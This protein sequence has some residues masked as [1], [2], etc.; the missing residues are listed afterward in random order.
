MVLTSAV[1]L[2]SVVCHSAAD[3]FVNLT[4]GDGGRDGR[5]D[6]PLMQLV[7]TPTPVSFREGCAD[8]AVRGWTRHLPAGLVA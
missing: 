7:T 3:I 4:R 6:A 5:T 8:A 1:D 2:E